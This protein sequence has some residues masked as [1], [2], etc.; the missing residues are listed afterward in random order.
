MGVRSTSDPALTEIQMSDSAQNAAGPWRHERLDRPGHW[1]QL[2]APEQVNALLLDF[3]PPWRR[4]HRITLARMNTCYS[5]FY[6]T[7]V[8]G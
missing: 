3:L 1:M 6:V 7:V 4:S 5:S 2:E 8:M